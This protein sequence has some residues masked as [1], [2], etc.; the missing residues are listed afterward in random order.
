MNRHFS[1]ED[2]QMAKRHEKVLNI[3]DHQGNTNQN[4]NI[5]SHW[6]EW[7]KSTIQEATGVGEDVE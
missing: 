1:E 4:Y 6:S 2:I 7:L 5:T 3:T